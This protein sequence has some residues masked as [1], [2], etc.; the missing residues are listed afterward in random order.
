[1]VKNFFGYGFIYS[2][3]FL[4][5]IS[6]GSSCS[7]KMTG[8]V[9]F[10]KKMFAKAIKL[11]SKD[12]ETATGDT[13]AA[14]LAFKIAESYRN[15]NQIVDAGKWYKEATK[16]GMNVESFYYH[17]EM[18]KRTGKYF[19]AIDAFNEYI[20]REG[21]DK[22]KAN[23]A[24]LGCKLAMEWINEPA[25]DYVVAP[26]QEIN[27]EFS[28][29]APSYMGDKLV[30]SSHRKKSSGAVVYGWNGE[31]FSDLFMAKL[32]GEGNPGIV[33]TFD[34]TNIINTKFHEGASSF[35]SDTSE[36]Y[37]TR[38][39]S[40]KELEIE[41]C[42]IFR[43]KRLPDGK[44]GPAQL[45]QLY[46]EHDT[47][48][49][50]QPSISPDGQY[51][52]FSTDLPQGYGGKDIYYCEKKMGMWGSPINM[53]PEINTQGE[54][55]YPCMHT[56][57]KFYF[58]SDGHI[59]MGG[60]D[61]FEA[62]R[63]GDQWQIYNMKYPLNSGADDFGLVLRNDEILD[64]SGY[65]VTRGFF[66]STRKGGMGCDD[67][68]GFSMVKDAFY[69]L[70][71]EVYEKVLQNEADPNIRVVDYTPLSGA[72][73]EIYGDEM[74]VEQALSG[75]DG[76]LRYK[77]KPNKE[78]KVLSSKDGYLNKS[79]YVPPVNYSTEKNKII[80]VDVE[81]I[82]D[83]SIKS[84]AFITVNNIYY[85][86]DAYYIREEAAQELDFYLIC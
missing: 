47:F 51:L 86:F 19:Q 29:Y 64:E 44:W 16:Y 23:I 1:M 56:D 71:V 37:F 60:L 7:R 45:V 13:A 2:L 78:Y 53:G 74:L 69:F 33:N 63:K 10:Q 41:Y 59:G 35:P 57:G 79:E 11:Y 46:G 9:A 28:D 14:V 39:G 6:F 8:D 75:D 70:N 30:F 65:Y 4:V 36:I 40:D 55:M 81:V 61:I 26:V 49:I 68:Y 66:T 54:D 72:T 3:I 24:V 18:L 77:L 85:D 21:A 31:K 17:A 15:A 73:I 43:S 32:D 76:K 25:Q 82:M 5:I 83:R 52:F 42:K 38:C 58:C 22:N 20:E 80:N 12:L 34:R 27:T 50:G 67:I 48:N 84:D 62:E